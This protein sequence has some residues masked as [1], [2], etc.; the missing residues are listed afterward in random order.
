MKTTP[1]ILAPLTK[2]NAERA[3]SV[4]NLAHP[5]WGVKRF[6]YQ[7]QPLH[8]LPPASTVGEG[9]N[10]AVLFESE[11][12]FWGVVEWKHIP[13]PNEWLNKFRKGQWAVR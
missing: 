5:E 12:K 6:N 7:A 2:E 10:S 3:A 1:T 11:Y 8:D 13:E 4:V 9:S